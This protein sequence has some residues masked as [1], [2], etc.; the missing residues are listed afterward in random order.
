MYM[1]ESKLIV[2]GAPQRIDSVLDA[3]PVPQSA[4]AKHPKDGSVALKDGHFGYDDETEVM[5]A[6]RTAQCMDI[7]EKL[8]T[9]SSERR[10]CTSPAASVS[11]FPSPV[12]S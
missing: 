11:V 8:F 4:E 6:L 1:S 2:A 9:P 5:A 12:R 10:A 3:E 7:I